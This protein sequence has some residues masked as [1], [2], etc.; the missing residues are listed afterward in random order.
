MLSVYNTNSK[1]W[2]V[3]L[4]FFINKKNNSEIV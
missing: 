2:F 1:I 4:W 3:V